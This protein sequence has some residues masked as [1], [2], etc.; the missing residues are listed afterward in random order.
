MTITSDRNSMSPLAIVRAIRNNGSLINELIQ[1]DIV[2]RY[3]GSFMGLLWSFFNP[4]LMLLV[5]T[6]VF[7]II[8][9]SR[10][11]GGSGSKSEFALVL[12]SGLMIFNFF[13]ECI[14]RAPGLIVGNVGYVKKIIFPLEILP[15][16]AMGAAL[17]HFCISFIVWLLF[18]VAFFGLP[19]PTLLLLPIA[20]LPLP[21]VIL[22]LS[23]FLSSLGV[24][25]RDTGHI[26]GVILMVMMFMTPIFYPISALPEKYRPLLRLNPLATLIE[27]AQSVMIWG[28]AVDWSV[29]GLTLVASLM[30]AFLGF[31]W[32]QKTRS[33]FSDVL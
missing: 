20:L 18:Y 25:L 8:F 26:I 33:G 24:Y 11:P 19:H 30:I 22:G 4:I 5:Y 21:F 10:W 29:W 27:Q 14:S 31:A 2:G 23:W 9:N 32:F 16:V 3:R 17:F 13:S 12:F 7:G 28:R 1:R 6:F 15:I